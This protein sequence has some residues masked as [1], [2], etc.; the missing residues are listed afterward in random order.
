MGELFTDLS[1]WMDTLPIFWAYVA[2]VGIAYG[3]NVIPPIPGDIGILYGGYLAGTGRLEFWPVVM[4]ATLGGALGFM[5]IYGLGYRVGAAILDPDRLRWVPK[6]GVEK[7]HVWIEQRGWWVVVFNRF[8]SGV[9]SVIALA[10]GIARMDA[11]RTAVLATLGAFI[12][13]TLIVYAGY[14]LGDN[15]EVVKGWMGIYGKAVGSLL[16]LG[17][18]LWLIRHAWRTRRKPN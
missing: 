16:A 11:R 12:W 1:G 4:L 9:R 2:I 18:G 10:V 17:I 3:E 8:L 15:L 13:T 7:A 6:K 14:A 5:T